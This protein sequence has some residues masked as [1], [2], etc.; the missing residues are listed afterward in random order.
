[1]FQR[2]GH[3]SNSFNILD[4]PTPPNLRFPTSSPGSP[5]IET[6]RT[7]MKENIW[8]CTEGYCG[9]CKGPACYCTTRGNTLLDGHQVKGNFQVIGHL[10]H[11]HTE[12]GVNTVWSINSIV[13]TVQCFFQVCLCTSIVFSVSQSKQACLDCD[14]WIVCHITCLAN[15]ELLP[16]Y[17][18]HFLLPC[19]DYLSCWLPYWFVNICLHILMSL[20]N[21]IWII[22]CVFRKTPQMDSI[23]GSTEGLLQFQSND[24]SQIMKPLFVFT[25]EDNT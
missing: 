20:A 5:C 8:R 25:T 9:Y 6:Q 18:P 23:S 14:F 1:M 16:V 12:Q 4:P 3:R 11:M 19:L 21:S 7:A 2:K 15:F 13:G 17:Q 10:K 24:I 22:C